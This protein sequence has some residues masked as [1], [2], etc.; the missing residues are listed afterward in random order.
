MTH[1][2]T[3]TSIADTDNPLRIGRHND[4]MCVLLVHH[5]IEAHTWTHLVIA[6][7]RG[8]VKVF[9]NGL[10]V[11]TNIEHWDDGLLPTSIPAS[12]ADIVIGKAE[13]TFFN[14]FMD[15]ITMWSIP[16]FYPLPYFFFNGGIELQSDWLDVVPGTLRLVQKRPSLAKIC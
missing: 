5:L 3:A 10:E 1:H 15:E 6:F 4:Q 12:G 7:D 11:E 13:D 9:K 14:G 8:T 16:L 2:H